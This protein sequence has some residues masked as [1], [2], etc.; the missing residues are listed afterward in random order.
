[1]KEINLESVL[2]ETEERII[3]VPEYV[4]VNLLLNDLF[5]GHLF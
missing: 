1:L 5:F 4:T 2:A 3:F